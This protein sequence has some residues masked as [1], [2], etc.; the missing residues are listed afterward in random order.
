MSECD[1]ACTGDASEICGGPDRILICY[2]SDA[3]TT[4]TYTGVI[5]VHD[6]ASNDFLGTKDTQ[7]GISKYSTVLNNAEMLTFEAPYWID[8]GAGR[9]HGPGWDR[10]V[11]VP[12][13]DRRFTPTIIAPSEMETGA[14]SLFVGETSHSAPAR[15][16]LPHRREPTRIGSPLESGNPRLG[17]LVDQPRRLYIS[18]LL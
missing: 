1:M 18:H 8:G 3:P 10:W 11:S 17:P 13:T 7:N 12:W 2:K 9:D 4:T 14:Q 6:S 16:V 15:L 5:E